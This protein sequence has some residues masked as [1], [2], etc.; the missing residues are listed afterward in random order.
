MR[1]MTD[2]SYLSMREA[3]EMSG[4]SLGELMDLVNAGEMSAWE[5]ETERGT[6]IRLLRTDIE[7]LTPP[8]PS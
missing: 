6:A 2:D 3:S 1:D 5:M 8:R 7:K 4:C